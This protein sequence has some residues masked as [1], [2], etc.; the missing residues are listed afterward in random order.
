M[1]INALREEAVLEFSRGGVRNELDAKL[2][3]FEEKLSQ[4]R[5]VL[6]K[7]DWV[8]GNVREQLNKEPER[9][10][11]VLNK[12]DEDCQEVRKKTELM[13]LNWYMGLITL[14]EKSGQNATAARQTA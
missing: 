6:K 4:L 12:V 13:Y 8:N 11:G 7:T 9:F 5:S 2:V 1:G 3:V 10:A 14:K